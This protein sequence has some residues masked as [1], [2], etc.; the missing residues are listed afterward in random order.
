MAKLVRKTP[1]LKSQGAKYSVTNRKGETSYYA[2][3]K[4]ADA[5]KAPISKVG[6][7]S[8]SLNDT[9]GRAQAMLAQTQAEGSKPFAGS[10]YE[11]NYLAGIPAVSTPETPMNVPAPTVTDVGDVVGTGNAGIAG[12]LGD[13]YT[14]AD[15]KFA[16]APQTGDVSRSLFEEAQALDQKYFNEMG[17]GEDR[18]RQLEREAKLKQKQQTV[19]DLTANLNQ[20]TA[21]RDAAVLGLEGTGRGQTEG[22]IGGEQ[23]RI[24]REAAI[25]ALP[26]QAQLAAAQ[27]A[28]ELAQSHVDKMFQIQS[29]DALQRYQY[30]S[31]LIDSAYNFL[32][33]QEQ[34]R[35]DAVR[36]KEDRA[37]EMQKMNIAM[38]NDWAKTALEYGQSNLVG[39]IMK[40]DPGSATFTTELAALQGKLSKPMG[41]TSTQDWQPFNKADGSTV[42]V[43][44]RTG[45][46]RPMGGGPTD[47]SDPQKL[48]ESNAKLD[49]LLKYTQDALNLAP[50]SGLGLY[51]RA[52]S[53]LTGDSNYNRLANTVDTL[54]TN[55][56]VLNTDPA[57]KKFFGPQMSN[58]DTELMTSAGTTL[59]AEKM[60]PSDM[61]TALT[62]YQEMLM[63]AK[64][65]VHL[66]TGGVLKVTLTDPST[67]KSQKVSVDYQSL[68]QA[69][70][71]GIQVKF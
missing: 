67:G 66:G 35:L 71:D 49:S 40:L 29:Q 31:K 55:A 45:E 2:S 56:L 58:R 6:G 47:T 13:S 22:F 53:F 26:V 50:A 28:L 17:T 19:N 25:A 20:I 37:Y 68:A 61:K 11:K 43:N 38:K 32:S 42:L 44:Q 18:M 10:S 12:L 70:R 52:A 65:W 48:S 8:Q 69:V 57:V 60:S 15:G 36:L 39:Q 34:R 3:S 7:S 21:S 59:N 33:A 63:R 64:G 16:P 5:G 1:S 41:S 62:D 14:Y 9:V 54:K 30:K 23:A 46:T 4:D 51:N 27:G 24:N